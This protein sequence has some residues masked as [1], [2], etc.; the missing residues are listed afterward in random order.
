M[1]LKVLEIR[2]TSLYAGNTGYELSVKE[3]MK[4]GNAF[5]CWEKRNFVLKW[6]WLFKEGNLSQNLNVKKK[7][8]SC[9]IFMCKES[10][11]KNFNVW[12]S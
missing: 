3:N 10:L 12:S 6:G 5:F 2:D 4:K 1:S 9:R 7:G 8:E 11:Q